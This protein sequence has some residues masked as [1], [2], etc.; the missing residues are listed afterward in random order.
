MATETDHNKKN[1]AEPD[2]G[3]KLALITGGN[4]GLG[5]AAAREL[6]RRGYRV[7]LTAR[8]HERAEQA[9]SALRAEGLDVLP[10]TLDVAADASVAAFL[11]RL[12]AAHPRV[13][14]LVNNAGAIFERSSDPARPGGAGTLEVAPELVL[15]AFNNNTLGAYRLLQA[16]LPRMNAA[17]YGRV[18][19]V[20]SG[21]GAL[22]GMD[23]G[24]PAYRISKTALNAVTRLFHNEARGDVKV[25]AVCPGWVRTD[26]GGPSA[27][28][29]VDEGV[30]GIV[31]AATL[32]SDG[33]SGAFLRDGAAI[34]W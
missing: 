16:I 34:D 32:A 6:A 8:D 7:L 18:V 24:W 9:A 27:A 25:N 10:E 5:L 13:D 23:S 33:P 3:P 21:M 22:E 15:A 28:R 1:P 19:N 31:L 4:R 20:S 30:H 29:S 17:G 12:W 11:E 2:S 14:V 26:M